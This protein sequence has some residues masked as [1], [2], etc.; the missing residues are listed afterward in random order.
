MCTFEKKTQIYTQKNLPYTLMN[1]SFSCLY[2]GLVQSL[3]RFSKAMP[4]CLRGHRSSRRLGFCI[5]QR[6]VTWRN[7][8]TLRHCH[9][10]R[11]G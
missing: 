11:S 4:S 2:L 8:P 9:S 5:F 1:F 6:P 3:G 7:T 10:G